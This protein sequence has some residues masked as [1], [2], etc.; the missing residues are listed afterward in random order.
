MA[1]KPK[2]PAKPYKPPSEDSIYK[3]FHPITGKR[4]SPIKALNGRFGMN[5]N[6][7]Q[8]TDE[9]VG[10]VERC[11]SL[12]LSPGE[13]AKI[14]GMG[15]ATLRKYYPD[16]LETAKIRK[17]LNVAEKLYSV[18]T[19]P[20]H[21]G[22]VTSAIFWLKAQGGWRENIQRMELSGPDGAPLQVDHKTHTIDPRALSPDQ[23]ENL[24]EILTAAMKLA[25]PGGGAPEGAVIDG[26][27]AE[28]DDDMDSEDDLV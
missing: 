27:W 7:H 1:A 20:E 22:F 25:A 17:N 19:N 14:A 3:A 23:R 21:K 15:E 5:A 26:E 2:P 6:E 12:G 4:I 24:R 8:R 9:K 28:T 16:V 13:T 10:V 11:M 18:A